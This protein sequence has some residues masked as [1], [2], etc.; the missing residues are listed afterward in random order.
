MTKLSQLFL[1]KNPEDDEQME[2][3]SPG[4]PE[5]LPDDIPTEEALGPEADQEAS[6]QL[7]RACEA[8]RNLIVEAGCKLNELEETKQTFFSIVDPAAQALRTLEHEKTRNISLNRRLGLLRASSEALQA[9]YDQVEKRAETLAADKD[10]LRLE[11]EEAQR[12]AR[13]LRAIKAELTND[14]LGVRAS[15]AS[16]EHQVTELSSRGRSLTEDNQ[17]YRTQAIEIEA[18]ANALES[19]LSGT[20]ET[21]AMVQ[22]E[23]KSLQNSLN[24]AGIEI[25]ELSQRSSQMESGLAAATTRIRQLEASLSGAE[26]ERDKLVIEVNV[27]SERERNTQAKA[28]VQLE[29]LQARAAMAE[30]LLGNTRQLL[31]TRNE[32]ARASEREVM[33]AKRARAAAESLRREI[34][35]LLRTHENH[36]RDL[37]TSRAAMTERNASLTDQLKQ[38]ESQFS[39]AEEQ[40]RVTTDQM[41]RLENEMKSSQRTYQKRIDE[42]LGILDRERLDRQVIESAL[43]T[44]RRERAQLQHE[45]YKMR[46]A[47]QRGRLPEENVETAPREDRSGR[48]AA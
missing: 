47:M 34:E 44:A 20:R 39:E 9:K 14:L 10:Q 28:Q 15:A 38:R 4:A 26:S 12:I 3:R 11:L 16:L 30:K 21:L 40:R 25:S 27:L 37:E 5:D 48:S 29:A 19:D 31:A 23:N 32:E 45:L 35:T 43:D 36:I 17:R 13:E 42:L 41:T 22:G 24:Q 6:A 18:H 33:E 1:R 7:G 8:L 46:R 2:F